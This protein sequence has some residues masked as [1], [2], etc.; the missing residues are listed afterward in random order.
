MTKSNYLF[1]ITFNKKDAIRIINK[2][3]FKK[4][5]QD[6]TVFSNVNDAVSQWWIEPPNEKFRCDLNIILNDQNEG[7]LYYFFIPAD[8]IRNPEEI[9]FQKRITGGTKPSIAINTNNYNFVDN[10]KNFKFKPYLKETLKYKGSTVTLEIER[11][12]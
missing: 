12:E 5:S 1:R 3:C 10:N 9:F 7:V 8:T 2:I 11:Y 6:D 4:I